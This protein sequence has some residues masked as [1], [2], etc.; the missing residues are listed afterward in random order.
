MGFVTAI[1]TG[2]AIASVAMQYKGAKNAASAAKSSSNAN[3]AMAAENARI[4]KENAADVVERGEIA[5]KD[6]GL[7]TR[8][9]IGS[10]RAYS[11]GAGV[12]LEGGTTSAALQDDIRYA[13]AADILTMKMNT[14]FEEQRALNQ[15]AQFTAQS[16]LYAKQAAGINPFMAGLTAGVGALNQNSDILFPSTP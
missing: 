3:S 11:A 7:R 5:Y 14:G 2:L 15:G 13:G 9:V 4:A 10:A 6:R 16:N 8:Q 1:T 12:S